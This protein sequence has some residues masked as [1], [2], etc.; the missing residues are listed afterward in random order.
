MS[1]LTVERP[2]K[3][4]PVT[5]GQCGEVSDGWI[6]DEQDQEWEPDF[7]WWHQPPSGHD[8]LCRRWC[9]IKVHRAS[10]GDDE[11]LWPCGCLRNDAGAHR[12][13]CPDHPEGVRG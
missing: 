12:V 10:C 7:E 13:G 2:P 4:A 9:W 6:W 8:F 3:P 5:C 1:D 11:C